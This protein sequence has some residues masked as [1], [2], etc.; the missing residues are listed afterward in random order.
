TLHPAVK[1]DA[2][3]ISAVGA[4]GENVYS[5][6]PPLHFDTPLS[7]PPHSHR[8]LIA[9]DLD[10]PERDGIAAGF[11]ERIANRFRDQELRIEVL[12]ERFEPRG[13]IHGVADHGI[14]LAS[15]RA[16]IAG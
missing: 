12:V 16:D 8:P 7:Q 11:A 13:E 6:I 4:V 15:R 3:S 5:D 10:L 2:K 9:P 14:F 1:L